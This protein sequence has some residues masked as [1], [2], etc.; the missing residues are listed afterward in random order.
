MAGVLELAQLVEDDRVPE[1][2]VGRRGID[3][4]LDAK[5]AALALGERELL[6]EGALGQH[7]DS[8]DHEVVDEASV[9]HARRSF[10]RGRNRR[11]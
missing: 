10:V 7:V 8:A 9:G 4:E 3:P 1:V 5:R 2:D 6:L 11:G